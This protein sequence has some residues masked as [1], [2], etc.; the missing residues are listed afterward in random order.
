MIILMMY[1]SL[2]TATHG[3]CSSIRPA[4]PF[5]STWTSGTLKPLQHM[6]WAQA[7]YSRAVVSL[8]VIRTATAVEGDFRVSATTS[9]TPPKKE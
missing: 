9:S 2:P 8:Q 7:L 3:P 1:I 4:A 6:E 5:S